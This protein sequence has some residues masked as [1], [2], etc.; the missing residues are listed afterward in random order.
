MSSGSP[1][2]DPGADCPPV[3]RVGGLAWRFVQAGFRIFFA[4]HFVLTVQRVLGLGLRCSAVGAFSG[5]A[6]PS[7]TARLSQDE[8]ERY[9]LVQHLGGPYVRHERIRLHAAQAENPFMRQ[10]QMIDVGAFLLAID[11]RPP[12]ASCSPAWSDK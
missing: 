6:I 9:T 12:S 3:H 8:Y 2:V 7:H 10:M 4:L 11:V 1:G 5:R